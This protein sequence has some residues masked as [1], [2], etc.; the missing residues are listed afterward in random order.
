MTLASTSTSRW[1]V[2]AR[3]SGEVLTAEVAKA[4]V[5]LVVLGVP[6]RYSSHELEGWLTDLAGVALE[7]SRSDSRPR[8]IPAL[9]HHALTGLLFSHA[10]LWDR[11]DGPRPCSPP[12]SKRWWPT[13]RWTGSRHILTCCSGR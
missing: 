10:E 8:S 7:T 5:R 3:T 1:A 9:L 2:S 13:S 12:R 6:E 4:G 11:L